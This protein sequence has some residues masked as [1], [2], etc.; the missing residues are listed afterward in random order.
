MLAIWVSSRLN[1]PGARESEGATR[2]FLQQNV[3]NRR[4]NFRAFVVAN[5]AWNF[6]TVVRSGAAEVAG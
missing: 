3:L 4:A 6:L 1:R 2:K 5:G